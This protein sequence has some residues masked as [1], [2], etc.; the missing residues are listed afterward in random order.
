MTEITIV[1]R[2]CGFGKSTDLIK[3]IKKCKANYPH[4]KILLVV[5]VLTEITRFIVEI[6]GDWLTTPTG[7]DGTKSDSLKDLLFKGKSIVITHA[8]YERLK[9]F[10]HLIA[11]YSVV[12]DEVPTVA[13]EVSPYI[14]AGTFKMILSKEYISI[15]PVTKVI[16]PK[17]GWLVDEGYFTSGVGKQIHNF[18]DIISDADVY[19]VNNTYQV[20]P[21][22]EAFFTAPKSLTI[23]T[24]LF[25]G[26]QLDYY[27]RE[28]NYVYTHQHD[29][30]ELTE[31]KKSMAT[32]LLVYKEPIPLKLGYSVMTGKSADAR[33][34]VGKFISSLFKK[35][36]RNGLDITP[37]QIL[38]ASHKDAFYG[39]RE[40]GSSKVSNKTSL[41]TLAR[42][43]KV[44]YTPL[45][46]RGT[47]KYKHLDVLIILG[48][49]NMNPSLAEFLGMRTKEAQNGY[50]TS[51][52][53]QLIYRT[54]IRDNED[55]LLI[56]PDEENVQLLHSFLNSVPECFGTNTI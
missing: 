36:K 44:E 12:I 5:P 43:S 47:N 20:M 7:D 50:A 11:E 41:M 33:K 19:F 54:A 31:F 18:M 48:Q 1:D 34:A 53:I 25:K 24:F 17:E 22:P 32:H 10:Q 6:G 49:L 8:L 55:I 21:L 35:F 28:R 26:T 42:L 39:Q 38:V 3:E 29:P 56:I 45:S 16:R 40:G 23:L 51:E 4:I 52:L 2:P 13:K 30:Y 9:S 14:D 15:D 46:T 27:M 37:D